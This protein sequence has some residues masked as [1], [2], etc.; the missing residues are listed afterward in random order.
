MVKK[1]RKKKKFPRQTK[2]ATIDIDDSGRMKTSLGLSIDF[3][4]MFS[5]FKSA[6][7]RDYR[8]LGYNQN[9]TL[10]S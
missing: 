1:I 6:Y 8:F 9:H 3:G 10:S 5:I 7:G 4:P 2:E